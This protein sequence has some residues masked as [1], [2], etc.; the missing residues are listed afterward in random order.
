MTK[1]NK[2]NQKK[3]KKRVFFAKKKHDLKKNVFFATLV[4]GETGSCDRIHR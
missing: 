1:K 3:Q 4:R 2:K